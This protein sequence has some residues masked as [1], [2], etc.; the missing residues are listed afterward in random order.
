MTAPSRPTAF[1][2]VGRTHTSKSEMLGTLPGV[3]VSRL[4]RGI[5]LGVL[6]KLQEPD[7]SVQEHHLS[8]ALNNW[9]HYW[10]TTLHIKVEV[11][12]CIPSDR[13]T[14]D[15][16]QKNG[17]THLLYPEALSE[18]GSGVEGRIGGQEMPVPGSPA[19]V[20]MP[21]FQGIRIKGFPS[22]GMESWHFLHFI[23][24]LL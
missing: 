22:L 23:S 16:L 11:I 15:W 8:V 3:A 13:R 20:S 12:H 18:S 4:S 24:V 9:R 14:E 21:L 6:S 1:P 5:L 7:I 2:L 10:W 17:K 19:S